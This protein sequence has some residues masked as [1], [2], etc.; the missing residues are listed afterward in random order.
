MAKIIKTPIYWS[1]KQFQ[2]LTEVKTIYGNKV[3]I[4]KRF[5]DSWDILTSMSEKI[6]SEQGLQAGLKTI[7]EL[8]D[9]E[10]QMTSKKREDFC[11]VFMENYQERP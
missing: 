2:P 8:M 1:E 11:K 10:N 3:K 9:S 5:K 7:K 4:P 6:I